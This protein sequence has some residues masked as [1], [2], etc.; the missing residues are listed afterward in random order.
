MYHEIDN[1]Y[2]TKYY[3]SFNNFLRHLKIFNAYKSRLILFKNL[4]EIS[5]NFSLFIITFDDGHISNMR[6]AKILKD[7]NIFATFFIVYDFIGKKDYLSASDVLQISEWGH[8]IGLHGKNHDSWLTKSNDLLYK[9]LYFAKSELEKLINK[10]IIV[11]SA[12]GGKINIDKFDFLINCDLGFKFIR[13][14]VPGLNK[15]NINSI[16]KSFPIY[17]KTN[18]STIVKL[19]QLDSIEI[20]KYKL[21]FYFKELAKFLFFK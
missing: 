13:G 4:D 15:T 16:I 21:F 17:S 14:S 19:F 20:L 12:P 11:A 2:K 7:N 1:N 5:F 9:E 8:E 6:A 18:L 10:S 3:V